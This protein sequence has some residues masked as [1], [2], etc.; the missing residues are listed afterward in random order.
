[1][2]TFYVAIL[3]ATAIKIAGAKAIWVGIRRLLHNPNANCTQETE[4]NVIA[5]Q[6]KLL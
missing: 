5:A 1:M 6:I 2:I 4:I 3:T